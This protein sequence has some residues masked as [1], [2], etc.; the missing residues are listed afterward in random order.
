MSLFRCIE[1]K[2]VERMRRN[3]EFSV[4]SF[5]I[6]LDPLIDQPNE[7]RPIVR[8]ESMYGDFMQVTPLIIWL[9]LQLPIAFRPST[10]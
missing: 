9:W 2:F 8:A 6:T 10:I 7:H 4:D 1:L 5:Q 3:F